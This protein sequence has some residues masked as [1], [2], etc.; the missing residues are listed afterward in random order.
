MCMS[1]SLWLGSSSTV[2]WVRILCLRISLPM[3]YGS[4]TLRGWPESDL[5]RYISPTLNLP[6][7]SDFCYSRYLL[8]KNKKIQSES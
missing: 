5:Y 8:I 7:V 2:F 1:A 6:C 4:L 3:R